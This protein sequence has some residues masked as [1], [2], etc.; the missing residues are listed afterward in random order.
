MISK[1][2]P[3]A[4]FG[5]LLVGVA[6]CDDGG[7]DVIVAPTVPLAYTRFVNAVP[8]TQPTD[9]RFID[10]L[11]NSPT[12]IGLAFRGFSPYQATAPGARKLRIFPADTNVN[13]VQQMLIDT[14]ITLQA[15]IYYTL[16]HL[17]NSRGNADRLLV[18]QDDIPN[19]Q[20]TN[21]AVRAMHLGT[22]LTNLDFFLS[23]TASS[24]PL[25]TTPSFGNLAFAAASAYATRN[26]GA[27]RVRATSAGQSTVLANAIAP[28]GA[29]AVPVDNLT[30]IGGSTMGG[31]AIT[32]FAFPR[33]VA[34]SRA[35][36][37]AAFTNPAIAYIID[38]HPPRQ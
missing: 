1:I 27:F 21:I 30:A 15:G 2:F 22:G 17:G 34:G 24:A 25:P 8:D 5:A 16:V 18:I 6:A 13:V 29:A 11:D 7:D 38:R 31:S 19:V 32:A 23:D 20:T 37:T 9:W 33:S 4:C 3:L 35:P 12:Q 14:T 26:P 36:Q 10:Q 28:P